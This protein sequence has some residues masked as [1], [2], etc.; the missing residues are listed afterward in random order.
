[1]MFN[2]VVYRR[3][4]CNGGGAVEGSVADLELAGKCVADLCVQ[5]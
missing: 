2:R 4:M 5:D 3:V 1:M